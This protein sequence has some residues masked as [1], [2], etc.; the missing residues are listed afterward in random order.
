MVGIVLDW[1]GKQRRS[2]LTLHRLLA[3]DGAGEDELQF[4]DDMKLSVFHM[5]NLPKETRDRFRSDM[6]FVVDYL[7]EG[8]FEGR[9]KQKIVH[10]EALCEMMEALTGDARF[11]EQ[12]GALLE[13]QEKG[14]VAMCEYIDLLEERGEKR[15]EKKGENRLAELIQRLLQEKKIGEI[16]QASSSA[17]KRQ[18]LYRLYGI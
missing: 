3:M 18:E 8:S 16:A 6:G 14:E 13:K 7:N 5:R 2:P 4:V 10:V 11:T 9:R 1:T 17:E 15:G 12:V